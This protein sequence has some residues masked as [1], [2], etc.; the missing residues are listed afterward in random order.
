MARLTKA[1]LSLSFAGSM[2]LAVGCVGTL[3]PQ[4]GGGADGG[5]GGG[6][7]AAV[8]A[9]ARLLFDTNVSPALELSCGGCHS[10][11]PGETPY[12]FL[13][14]VG[15]NDNYATITADPALH[16]GWNAAVSQLMVHVHGGGEPDPTV[17]QKEA[18]TAWLAQEALERGASNIP[19]GTG[20]SSERDALAKWSAC[21]QQ[22]DW[23]LANMNTWADL[24]SA[25]GTCKSCHTYG[26]GGFAIMDTSTD[27]FEMN[28]YE[29]Y[30]N[31]FFK[32]VPVG[33]GT[34]EVQPNLTRPCAKADGSG[35][36][37]AY[38]CAQTHIDRL[39]NFYNITNAK[40]AACNA[41]PAFPVPPP[42]AQ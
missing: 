24:A 12:K 35:G 39:Q 38:L 1:A 17:A 33:D 18:I 23:D 8:G 31:F 4:Q 36:H 6:A 42:P 11:L 40:L 19:P 37:P 30:I 25:G 26:A 16:G 5:V 28:R 13:G 7:D 10:G 27:S 15:P 41:I 14:T 3:E 20:N 32:A 2:A 29:I 9:T 34:F 21:V 22:A